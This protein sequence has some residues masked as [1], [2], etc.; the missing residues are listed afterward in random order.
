MTSYHHAIISSSYHHIIMPG[1]EWNSSALEVLL[2][3]S[4][5]PSDST[6]S[7]SSTTSWKRPYRKEELSAASPWIDPP[8]PYMHTYIQRSNKQSATLCIKTSDMSCKC[9]KSLYLPTNQPTYLPTVIPLNSGTTAGI[10]PYG[11]R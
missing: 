5:V 3:T 2:H 11:R 6:T 4:T 8:D 10:R 7:I 9:Q 1:S